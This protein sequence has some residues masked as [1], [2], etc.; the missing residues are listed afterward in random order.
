M[1][2]NQKSPAGV[3]GE[4]VKFGASN[5]VASHGQVQNFLMEVCLCV[6]EVK[7]IQKAAVLFVTTA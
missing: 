2:Q 6:D 4:S 3:E 5:A 1:L 7:Q